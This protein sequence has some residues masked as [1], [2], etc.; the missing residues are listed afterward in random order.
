MSG[1][2]K[3]QLRL[4]APYLEGDQWTHKNK[5]GEREWNMHCPVHEDTKRSAS[6]NI[7]SGL[8]YC[9]GGC[10][11]GR[12]TE[13]LRMCHEWV[14]LGDASSNG[15]G[16]ISPHKDAKPLPSEAMIQGWN[17]ALLGSGEFQEHLRDRGITTQTMSDYE[18]GFNQDTKLYMIP[19]R[20]EEGDL[21]NVRKYNPNPPEGRRKIWGITGHNEPRMFPVSILELAVKLGYVIVCEGEWD[22]LILIQAGYPAITRT[23]AADVWNGDWSES[24]A[25]LTVYLCHDCDYKGQSANRKLGRALFRSS[26]VRTIE[27]PY[28]LI[29]KHGKDVSDFWEDNAADFNA[30]FD[31]LMEEAKKWGEIDESEIDTV[32][33]LDSFD[34]V[35]VGRPTRMVVTIKGRKEPGYS[36][37]RKVNLACTRDAGTKCNSCPLKASGGETE[38]MIEPSDP[39]ILGIVDAPTSAMNK[40]IATAYGIPGGQ[41]LK[42]QMQTEEFQAV[43]VLFARPSI[44]HADGTKA[45]A[46]KSIRITNVGHHDTMPNTT[47]AVTGTLQPN[48]RSQT[49]DFQAWNLEHLETNVDRFTMTDESIKMMR[50]FQAGKVPPLKR[51]AQISR[52][53]EHEVTK[54][55][56]R[57]E[58]HVMMDL[59]FH[60]VLRF[61]FAG[62][63]VARGW[64]EGIVAGDTRTG[65]SDVATGLIRHYR[66]G[67]MVSGE[68]AS[69]AGLVG[70]VQQLGGK[71]WVVTWGVIPINHQ[72]IVV[73][74]ELSGLPPEDIAKMSDVRSSGIA[75]ISKIQQDVTLSATRLLWL[76]NPRVGGMDQFTYGVDLLRPL[77]G[78]PEDIARFDLA[79]AVT[80]HDVPSE[81]INL[82]RAAE[83]MQFSSDACHTMLMWCWTRR[84]EQVLWLP[85]SEERVLKLANEMGKR[86]T[87]NPPL[88]QAANIRIK[89][90]RTAVAIAGRL[91][92]TDD[93]CENIV[94]GIPHVDAA[95]QFMDRIYGMTAFGYAERSREAILDKAEAEDKKETIKQ[96]LLGRRTLPKFLRQTSSFRRADLEE[97]MNTSREEANAIINTLWEARMVRKDKGDIRVEPTL[98]ALL[99]EVRW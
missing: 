43:E 84:P 1:V 36:V 65:K 85:G 70:G 16:K 71:E 77:I 5:E 19:I 61:T 24:L 60:S 98:H 15:H 81:N 11:G 62:D 73:I 58:M 37:P 34:A 95:V 96:Y 46:Y 83:G 79:M 67:E 69:L 64:L 97:I 32:T 48:P 12:V 50:L 94:V 91:F 26:D 56:G 90:A 9:Q 49:N 25:G 10:G 31:A 57:P 72:R 55:Y 86:Y 99:R 66:A 18:I 76:S 4:L 39:V 8:W 13:L 74:D 2:T 88:I 20:D 28:P 44:E 38:L 33:V 93:T 23:A 17:A 92:S 78:N 21:V 51:L 6:I 41:C 80:L 27:L 75:R 82:M 3:G 52:A 14:P 45:D 29:P 53:L 42:L 59:I 54:I 89:I 35:R 7:D 40:L 22:C 68:T 47:V 63:L 87:E 30:A